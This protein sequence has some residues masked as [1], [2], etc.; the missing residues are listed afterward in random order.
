[1]E[2]EQNPSLSL[3]MPPSTT[4]STTSAPNTSQPMFVVVQQA[5]SRGEDKEHFAKMFPKMIVTVLSSVQIAIFLMSVCC[6]IAII[7]HERYGPNNAAVG[8]W[9]P[10]FFGMA[11]AVGI[12]AAWKPSQCR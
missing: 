7:R 4:A 5:R 9:A 3:T 8:F 12:L 6:S 1:M 11:G 2:T 10:V